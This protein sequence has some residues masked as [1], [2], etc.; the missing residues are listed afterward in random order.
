MGILELV[1]IAGIC[2]ILFAPVAIVL[3]VFFATKSTRTAE[4]PPV[5]TEKAVPPKA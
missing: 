1:V 4:V 2:L 3:L 5:V